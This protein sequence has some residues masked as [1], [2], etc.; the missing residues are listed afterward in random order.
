M[1]Y[2]RIEPAFRSFLNTAGFFAEMPE[3]AANENGQSRF[4]VK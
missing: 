4:S 1:P 3:A 2:S